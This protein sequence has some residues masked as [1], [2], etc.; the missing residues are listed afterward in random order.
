M[1][2]NV[3]LLHG[4]FHMRV[5]FLSWLHCAVNPCD[6]STIV[7]LSATYESLGGRDGVYEWSATPADCDISSG[8]L[9]LLNAAES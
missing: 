4:A 2:S 9:Q 7:E 1:T 6:D 3:S 5:S 8:P